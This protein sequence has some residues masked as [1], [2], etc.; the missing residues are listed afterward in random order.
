M[1]DVCLN[2]YNIRENNTTEK[3]G[4]KSQVACMFSPTPAD[5]KYCT[6]YSTGVRPVV[7]VPLVLSVLPLPLKRDAD[8]AGQALL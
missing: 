7:R 3:L 6:W 1:S 2:S 4:A 5:S 8:R